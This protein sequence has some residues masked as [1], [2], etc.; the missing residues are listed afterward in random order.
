MKL[1]N[2]VLKEAV[3]LEAMIRD[4]SKRLEEIKAAAKAHGWVG[5]RY[6]K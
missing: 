2:E 4:A 5:K 1:T 6:Q 3:S